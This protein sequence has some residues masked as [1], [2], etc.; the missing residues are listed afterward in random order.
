MKAKDVEAV[1]KCYAP[2]AIL[3]GRFSMT[4]VPK[5]GGHASADP[6]PTQ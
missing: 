2:D 4:L 1:L 3:W 5:A 6:A